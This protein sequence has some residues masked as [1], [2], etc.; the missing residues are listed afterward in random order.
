MEK[1]YLGYNSN[2]TVRKKSSSGGLFYELA[3]SVLNQSGVIYGAAFN[4]NFEVE[5]IRVTE[6]K[7]LERLLCSKYVQS[8][9][10]NVYSMVAEDLQN[11][12]AV[13]FS[14][15]PCQVSGLKMLLEKRN[16][17]TE[18]LIAV[19]FICHGVPS[20]KV[21]ESYLQYLSN[22]G[23]ISAVN[24][25]HK[26]RGWHDFYLNIQYK[27]NKAQSMSHELDPY[28]R[29]FLSDKNI[30]PSCYQCSFKGKNYLSDI[31]LGDAWKIE[32]DK[33]EWAD[34]KGTSLFIVR[35]EKGQ[36]L[37]NSIPKSFLTAQA[38]YE[39]WTAFNPSIVYATKRADGRTEFFED[40]SRLSTNE[41]WNKYK[42]VPIK[43]S[44]KYKAKRVLKILRLEKVARKFA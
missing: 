27:N 12:H 18:Q 30:R 15:T 6:K 10:N 4:E 35:T 26:A 22:R 44:I 43:K 25:R 11:N 3:I 5:H 7:Q 42:K 20:P 9:M 19:D 23:D 1:T 33:P 37:L 29:G 24:F 28:M 39:K 34:D 38:D 2:E 21:W 13:L 40:F 36:K 16:I 41:F 32:K 31:T 17:S 8:K 14:G